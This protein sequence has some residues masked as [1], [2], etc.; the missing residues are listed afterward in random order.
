MKVS[1]VIVTYNHV[2]YIRNAI[3]GAL[4][5]K[6]NFEYEICIG[7]DESNDGTRE[8]C[9]EYAN[10]YPDK[11]RLFLRSRKDVIYINGHPTGRLNFIETL[12]QTKGKYIAI[13]DGDDYW[14]DP[15][16]LQKQV[17]FLE[18]NP[19]YG[20][21]HTNYNYLY[22]NSE[23]PI[24]NAHDTFKTSSLSGNILDKLILKNFIGTLTVVLRKD[25]VSEFLNENSKKIHSWKMGDKPIWLFI[26][27]KS[28]IGYLDEVTAVRR[29][30]GDSV[31]NQRNLKKK[32]SF[33]FSSNSVSIF[34][35]RKHL[36]N[37]KHRIIIILLYRRMIL[38][39][40]Y[41]IKCLKGIY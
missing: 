6:T 12:K 18:E 2:K 14:I 26:A 20:M 31:S 7:E 8:I 13:C 15:N 35:A 30:L 23:K 37:N 40:K 4:M 9:I 34:F 25:L 10:K 22:F 24:K 21:I 29:R 19:E 38:F 36:K 16:K 3:V 41:M 5:Q 1:V 28:K 11:I 32:F 27:S 39:S 33:F 17:D